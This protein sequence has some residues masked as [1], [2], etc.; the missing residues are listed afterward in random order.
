[1]LKKEK[2]VGKWFLLV[3]HEDLRIVYNFATE[4]GKIKIIMRSER[5]NWSSEPLD[6]STSNKNKLLELSKMKKLISDEKKMRR[7]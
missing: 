5:K 6:V 1:M 2:Q 4:G 3:S 7:G